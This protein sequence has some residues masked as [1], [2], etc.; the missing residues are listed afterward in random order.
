HTTYTNSYDALN[1]NLKKG[2]KYFEID[3]SYTVDNQ[4]VCLHDWKDSFKRSFGFFKEKKPTLAEFK[5]LVQE[6]S[7]FKKCT[8]DGLAVWMKENPSAYIITD[9]KP[10]NR[11]FHNALRIIAETLPD[12]LNRVIPQ[13][14]Y[15]K[16][17]KKVKKLGFKQIIWT[18]YRYAG[19]DAE[20]LAMVDTLEPPLAVTMP[21]ERGLTALPKKLQ[22]KGV[23]SYVH[24]INGQAEKDLLL[25]AYHVT[26]IYTDFLAD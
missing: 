14:Y 15:P 20:V 5:Q 7:K 26:E 19:D 18:L 13:I 9:I 1:L 21:H 12:S 11:K 4:L 8:L 25:G 16:Q 22:E 3:F 23:P 17:I 2:F 6:K 24:T 10:E